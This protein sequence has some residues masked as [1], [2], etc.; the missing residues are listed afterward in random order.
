MTFSRRSLQ[1]V[2]ASVLARAPNFLLPIVAIRALDFSSYSIFAVGFAA[3]ASMAS[4][5]GEA[6]ASTISRESFRAGQGMAG[7]SSLSG[8]FRSSILCA[9]LLI[10]ALVGLYWLYSIGSGG[11]GEWV[12]LAGLATI[13]LTPAYLMPGA[14]AALANAHGRGSVATT[15][16]IVGVPV[17]ITCS[18]LIGSEYGVVYFLLTYCFLVVLTNSIVFV[19]VAPGLRSDRSEG[20]VK[21]WRDYGPI[22]LTVL[23]PFLLG[24]PVHG[25]CLFILG[26]GAGGSTEL[27][28][29]VA[30]YPWSMAVSIFSAILA[31]Y[32]IQT[33][34]E[35]E[36][37]ADVLGLRKFVARLLPLSLAV[38]TTVAAVLWG[39]M[40]FVFTLYGPAF[41]GSESLF[42]WMLIC[43]I[44][45][46][47]VSTTSQ[48]LIGVGSRRGLVFCAML[49]AILYVGLCLLLIGELD[50]G[51]VGLARSLSYSLLTLALAHVLLIGRRLAFNRTLECTAPSDS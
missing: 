40:D 12:W 18:L 27:A 47:I 17:S 19:K 46:A 50:L 21:Q 23:M 22:L 30:Y 31:N 10:V 28:M 41:A 37:R 33:V 32:V 26:S 39:G 7:S 13:L 24:G 1:I 36:R 25:L 14:V 5:L 20:F 44:V 6:I 9:Y 16:S 43:G 49:H 15:A 48:I 11:G 35:V 4:C 2:L 51:A 42:S 34:V 29:F 38:A 8:F 45:S 3:A